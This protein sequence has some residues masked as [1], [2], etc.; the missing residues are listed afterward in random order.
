MP[1]RATSEYTGQFLDSLRERVIDKYKKNNERDVQK[2]EIKTPGDNRSRQYQRFQDDI[3]TSTGKIL[4]RSLLYSLLYRKIDKATNKQVSGVDRRYEIYTIE[5]LEDY[6]NIVRTPKGISKKIIIPKDLKGAEIIDACFKKILEGEGFT[7]SYTDFYLAKHD[8]YCQWYGVVRNWDCKRDKAVEVKEQII[9][10]FKW[11]SR[12]PAVIHGPGGCGKSTFLRR[13]AIDYIGKDFVVLWVN[14][15]GYFCDEDLIKIRNTSTKYLVFIEDWFSIEKDTALTTRFLNRIKTIE[16]VRIVIGDRDISDK[17]YRKQLLGNN[18]FELPPEDNESI[19]KKVVSLNKT[20]RKAAEEI[21]LSPEIYNTPLFL[22]LFVLARDL[23][24]NEFESTKDIFSRFRDIIENDQRKINVAYPGL[25]KALYYWSCIYQ[26]YKVPLLWETFLKIADSYNNSNGIISR[27]FSELKKDNSI[28]KILSHYIS[29]EELV[30]PDFQN[31]H[32]FFYHHDLLVS[33]GL[34]IPINEN[35]C[36][37]F[38]VKIELLDLIIDGGDIYSAMDLFFSISDEEQF[39]DGKLEHFFNNYFGGVDRMYSLKLEL[40]LNRFLADAY[41]Q[42]GTND[43]EKYWNFFLIRIIT[44]FKPYE[45]TNVMFVLKKV[46]EKGCRNEFLMLLYNASPAYRYKQRRYMI[47]ALV[48]LNS[49]KYLREC[50][51]TEDEI[52]AL[53]EIILNKY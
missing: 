50:G 6:T 37:D 29:L 36:Y 15:L 31:K 47:E 52:K 7:H 1:S 49:G 46:I 8:N 48:A 9:D 20:W 26:E 41:I 27:Q 14:D 32:V 17:D 4:S 33:N 40:M 11:E 13:L 19:I 18:Y 16:N 5:T 44:A 53:N 12:I 3:K 43:D 51:Y 42:A 10:C 28:G 35:W 23:D 39:D 45:D 21:L 24:K 38:N 34:S 22:I 2:E 25:G 30:H